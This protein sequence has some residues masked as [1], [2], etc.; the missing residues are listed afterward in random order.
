MHNV[1]IFG[2][3]GHGSVVLDCLEKEG[4]YNVIGFVDSFKKKG[5]LIFGYEV[6]GSEY[7]LP[8]IVSKFNIHGGIVAVGDNWTRKLM[9]DRILKIQPDFYFINAIHPKAT[10]GKDVLLG[11]GNVLMPGS[12][13]NTNAILHDFCIVNTN[14]SLDDDGIMG[15]YSSLAPNSC[16]GGNVYVGR[17]SAVCL[18]A[19]VIGNVSIGEHTLIGAG[20]LVLNDFADLL[21]AHGSP[22]RKIRSRMIGEPYLAVSKNNEA[23]IPMNIRKVL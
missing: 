1:I 6:L 19:N 16:L 22:A 9:V 23:Y 18:G 21:I 4:S 12:V 15:S 20:A 13:V 14:A 10:V 8:Y 3:S 7:D 17:F 5:S 11:F 2:A